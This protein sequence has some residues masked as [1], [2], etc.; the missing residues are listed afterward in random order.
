MC[1]G[2]LISILFFGGCAPLVTAHFLNRRVK[3]QFTRMDTKDD[4]PIVRR[5]WDEKLL[6]DTTAWLIK[7]AVKDK[8]DP[9][10][11]RVGKMASGWINDAMEHVRM[12]LATKEAMVWDWRFKEKWEPIFQT[13]QTRAASP[14]AQVVLACLQAEFSNIVTEFNDNPL[15]TFCRF[16]EGINGVAEL[17]FFSLEGVMCK[18]KTLKSVVEKSM[19]N[20]VVDSLASAMKLEEVSK[21]SQPS[22]VGQVGQDQRISWSIQDQIPP[23]SLASSSATKYPL[24]DEV[25]VVLENLWAQQPKLD[26][27]EMVVNST[28]E[29]WCIDVQAMAVCLIQ[30]SQDKADPSVRTVRDA[31]H[32]PLVRDAVHL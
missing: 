15:S 3:C 17:T 28:Y 27:T 6:A 22:Q 20:R 16:R 26:T 11:L 2:G 31:W 13:W 5:S 29:S 1:V 14:T 4:K 9:Q 18:A 12:I 23:H 24:P 10:R 32:Y 19:T 30:D 7:T 21:A 25:V 8:K